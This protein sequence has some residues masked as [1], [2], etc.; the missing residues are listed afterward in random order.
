MT[1]LATTDARDITASIPAIVGHFPGRRLI[2]VVGMTEDGAQSLPV[3]ID[4]PTTG[5]I[6]TE[7]ILDAVTAVGGDKG[8]I[9]LVTGENRKS[10]Q[11]LQD[12]TDVVCA[13]DD[14]GH[15]FDVFIATGF[16]DHDVIRRS[17]RREDFIP[18]PDFRDVAAA[19][20]GDQHI[21]MLTSVQA[22]YASAYRLRSA[23]SVPKVM[24]FDELATL[25]ALGEH[26]STPELHGSAPLWP[27][28]PA[29]S[30]NDELIVKT[31]TLCHTPKAPLVLCEVLSAKAP[32]VAARELLHMAASLGP[33]YPR[34]VMVTI[35]ATVFRI[36]GAGEEITDRL[37]KAAR[38]WS[39]AG[40]PDHPILTLA[41]AGK[42]DEIVG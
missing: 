15:P 13:L 29:P 39:P 37:L 20:V 11:P 25:E 19:L 28:M 5:G 35:T 1:L 41:E 36:C 26:L 33:S 8:M 21:A 12:A 10:S 42:W 7:L 34:V 27:G 40:S 6:N 38:Q 17:G 22:P 30:S 31:A 23:P 16:T 32:G 9:T 14:A 3:L 2:A 18:L 4:Y 24:E